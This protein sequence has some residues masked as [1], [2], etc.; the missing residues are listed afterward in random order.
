[1]ILTQ[2]TCLQ[3]DSEP[4]DTI[5]QKMRENWKNTMKSAN[6]ILHNQILTM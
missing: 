6:G 4:S 2:Q 5:K 3:W 1:M